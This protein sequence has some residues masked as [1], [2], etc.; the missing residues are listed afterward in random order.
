MEVIYEILYKNGKEDVI[1]QRVKEDN[2]S[3]IEGITN[4]FRVCMTEDVDG[5]VTFGDGKIDGY[6]VRV[7]DVSRVKISTRED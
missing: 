5:L 4:T 2:I 7:A 1:T 6:M 3:E